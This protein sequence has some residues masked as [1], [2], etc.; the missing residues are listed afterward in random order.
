MFK[1]CADIEITGRKRY[2]VEDYEDNEFEVKR[3]EQMNMSVEASESTEQKVD[4]MIKYL[5]KKLT[6]LYEAKDK[7]LNGPHTNRQRK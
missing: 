2:I 1:G 5:T 4:E 7:I 6:Q 3:E